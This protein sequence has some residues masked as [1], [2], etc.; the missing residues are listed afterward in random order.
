MHAHGIEVFDRADDH[1]VVFVV[2]H[3]LELELFPAEHR[4]FD[5][6]L[7][8]RRD[9]HARLNDFLE[10]FGPVSEIAAAA[11]ESARRADDEREVQAFLNA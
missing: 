1:H 9:T 4:F 8:H 11:A 2:A 5:Q 7:M 10:I 3:H 6:D